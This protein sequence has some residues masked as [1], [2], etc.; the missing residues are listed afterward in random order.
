MVSPRQASQHGYGPRNCLH[1]SISCAGVG[2]TDRQWYH[3]PICSTVHIRVMLSLLFLPL[4][5]KAV[6]RERFRIK[7]TTFCRE[8]GC[9]VSTSR[10]HGHLAALICRC[11]VIMMQFIA[12]RWMSHPESSE[13]MVETLAA[14]RADHLLYSALQ[15]A[16]PEGEALLGRVL[17]H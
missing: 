8:P 16:V 6:H 2:T 10:A 12:F 9:D 3:R 5:T 11:S 7:T 15:T 14:Y 17:G 13:G 1:S 4:Q